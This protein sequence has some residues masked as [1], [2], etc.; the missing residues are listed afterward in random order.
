MKFVVF[1]LKVNYIMWVWVIDGIYLSV[2]YVN[3]YWLFVLN[4]FVDF[5]VVC[6]IEVV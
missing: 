6:V 2:G 5:V 4:F 1:V 3:V